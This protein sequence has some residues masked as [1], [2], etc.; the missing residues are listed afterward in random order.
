MQIPFSSLTPSSR[1]WMPYANRHPPNST[2]L[3]L[4]FLYLWALSNV[5]T[6]HPT[7]HYYLL[8]NVPDHI[9]NVKDFFPLFSD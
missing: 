3:T 2:F 5:Y 9:L 4:N 7:T 6:L 1:A 8:M